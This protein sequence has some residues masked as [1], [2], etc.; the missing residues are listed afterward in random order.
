M[1]Q[2]LGNILSSS[3]PS[4]YPSDPIISRTAKDNSRKR[5][6]LLG[7]MDA[8]TKYAGVPNIDLSV[9]RMLKMKMNKDRGNDGI[10]KICKL[11]DF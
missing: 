9:E 10:I 3:V 1:N 2:V 5:I 4:K 11:S 8:Y 7:L 6:L